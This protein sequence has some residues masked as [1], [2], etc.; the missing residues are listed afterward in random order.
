MTIVIES[1]ADIA[2]GFTQKREKRPDDTEAIM[3]HLKFSECFVPRE[4]IDELCGLDIGWSQQALFDEFGDPLVWLEMTVPG[5][6][7]DV[8]GVINGIKP[9]DLLKINTAQL[10]GVKL[11]LTQKG[12]LLSGEIAWVIA[13]DESS[14]L[15]PLQ[16]NVCR[17]KWVIETP[18]QI[19]MIEQQRNGKAA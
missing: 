16:G 18:A 1:T 12:A 17:V 2:K 15:V 7:A 5:L 4:T 3:G 19:D 13:G 10:T 8:T 11:K 9:N 6:E 14:D